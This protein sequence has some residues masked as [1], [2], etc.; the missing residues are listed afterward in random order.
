MF[1]ALLMLGLVI[2]F[3]PFML[4][5]LSQ[6]TINAENA[7]VA[8]Q[9]D[10]AFNAA[11]AWI[12]ENS[13]TIPVGATIIDGAKINSTFEP[14]GLQ[15]GFN[16]RTAIG[17]EIRIV[18]LRNGAEVVPL[19]EAAGGALSEVRRG[20]IA[21]RIGFWGAAVSDG[22]LVGATGDWDLDTSAEF[23]FAPDPDSIFVRVPIEAEASEFLARK[24][25]NPEKN[26]MQADIDMLY[27]NVVGAKDVKAAG[28]VFEAGFFGKLHLM[29]EDESKN[30]NEIE[31]LI[32]QNATFQ[33]R[34]ASDPALNVSRGDLA[35][36]SMSVKNVV[37]Y[38]GQAPNLEA[39]F[40][41]VLDYYQSPGTAS[42]QGPDNWLVRGNAELSNTALNN[43]G[44]VSV[45][46]TAEIT[47]D[48]NIFYDDAVGSARSG[49]TADTASVGHITLKD[50]N[51]KILTRSPSSA[52]TLLSV[53]LAGTS[54][55]PD[56]RLDGINNDNIKIPAAAENNEGDSISCKSLI[57]GV[58][59]K[60]EGGDVVFKYDSK[61]LAQQ[62]ACLY[63]YYQRLE[64]RID[65]K[66]CLLAGGGAKKCGI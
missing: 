51:A 15:I 11:S 37:S 64:K 4:S 2:A 7:A 31:S 33:S 29:G 5:K 14:Y 20:E 19:I 16:A 34:G 53:R 6:R 59:Y 40:V 21:L 54:Q 12:K 66:K 17:Q 42:F 49:I 41:S 30:K 48:S 23:G 28:A 10:L 44:V 24:S 57:E 55:L 60:S 18:L 36:G 56:V 13:D 26:A 50:Q 45:A 65:M 61:S 62:T 43:I 47:S 38:G 63:A 52:P 39:G 3:M 9:M 22:K 46:G 27:N 35:V 1:E 25:S 58:R 8:R 32:V